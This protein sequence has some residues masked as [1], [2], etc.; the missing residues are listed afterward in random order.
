MEVQVALNHVFI[1]PCLGRRAE[2]VVMLA[3]L[4]FIGSAVRHEYYMSCN[5]PVSG[6]GGLLDS[7]L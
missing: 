6:S 1:N 4:F 7:A 5:A 2:N 3:A